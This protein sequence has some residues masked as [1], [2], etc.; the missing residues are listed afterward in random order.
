MLED[1][2]NEFMEN[3]NGVIGQQL[4]AVKVN[5]TDVWLIFDEDM[6]LIESKVRCRCID[7]VENKEGKDVRG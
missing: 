4:H 6:I 7:C 1:E 5:G 3:I 2:L